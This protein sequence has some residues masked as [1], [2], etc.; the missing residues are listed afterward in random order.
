MQ[1][2]DMNLRANGWYGTC[3]RDGCIYAENTAKLHEII[4]FLIMEY[5]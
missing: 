1:H 3:S 2:A 5:Y 4:V